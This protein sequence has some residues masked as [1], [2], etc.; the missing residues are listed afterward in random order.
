[1]KRRDKGILSALV[2]V[3]LVLAYAGDYPQ[4]AYMTR[5]GFLLLVGITIML[6]LAMVTAWEYMDTV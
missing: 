1:M 2:V 6:S 3:A 4:H 5:N